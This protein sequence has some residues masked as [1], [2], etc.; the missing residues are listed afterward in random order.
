[1]SL[2]SNIQDEK[3]RVSFSSIVNV[4]FRYKVWFFSEILCDK[5]YT[6]DYPETSFELCEEIFHWCNPEVVKQSIRCDF[7][8]PL[9]YVVLYL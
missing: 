2:L 6:N 9:W 1:M 5:L 8:K 4:T 7:F 3:G